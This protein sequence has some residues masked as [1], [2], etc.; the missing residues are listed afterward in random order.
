MSKS[1]GNAILLRM[2]P[3][4]TAAVIKKSPTDSERAVSYDP[5]NRPGI[6]ALL[7]ISAIIRGLEPGGEGETQIA[8][9]INADPKYGAGLLKQKTTELV[10]DF[11]AP[12]RAR[13]LEL[14]DNLDYI[15]DVLTDGNEKAREI[16]TQT[17]TEVREAMGMI[18]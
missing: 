8:E 10:N 4:E 14:E 13:R 12:L 5:D 6:S 7:T 2:T 1:F 16:A 11:F 15:R 3:D 18:Y 9:E 17:L